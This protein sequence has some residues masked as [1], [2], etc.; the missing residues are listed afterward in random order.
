MDELS[1]TFKLGKTNE[2]VKILHRGG[3][4]YLV[5][6][7]NVNTSGRKVMEVLLGYFEETVIDRKLTYKGE[8]LTKSKIEQMKRYFILLLIGVVQNPDYID[9]LYKR[10]S[11]YEILIDRSYFDSEKITKEI[12]DSIDIKSIKLKSWISSVQEFF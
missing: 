4:P 12:R 11:E 1:D 7:P 10:L 3:E 5:I 9:I 6:L 2:R 8:L